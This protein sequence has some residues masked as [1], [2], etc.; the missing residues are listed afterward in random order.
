M[1]TIYQDSSIVQSVGW[2]NKEREIQNTVYVVIDTGTTDIYM[3]TKIKT[4]G[5]PLTIKHTFKKLMTIHA[6]EIVQEFS[7]LLMTNIPDVYF[8]V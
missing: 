7:G 2:N 1:Y 4:Y 8:R 5:F 6:K 3:Y